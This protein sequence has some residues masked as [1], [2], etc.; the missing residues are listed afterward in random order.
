MDN[1]FISLPFYFTAPGLN[2]EIILE[3]QQDDKSAELFFNA[4]GSTEL[5]LFKHDH[6]ALETNLKQGLSTLINFFND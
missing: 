4:D 3:Y 2:G 6:C 1:A 5:L